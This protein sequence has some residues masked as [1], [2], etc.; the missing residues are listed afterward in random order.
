MMTMRKNSS[1]S[2]SPRNNIEKNVDSSEEIRRTRTVHSNFS[3]YALLQYLSSSSPYKFCNLD[4][5]ENPRRGVRKQK[6]FD[7][8]EYQFSILFCVVDYSHHLHTHHH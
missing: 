3:S 4:K 5:R 1:C 6:A 7:L 8:L 2:C